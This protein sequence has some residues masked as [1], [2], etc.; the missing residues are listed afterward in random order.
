[1]SAKG[2]MSLNMRSA[3]WEKGS[4][5]GIRRATLSRLKDETEATLPVL[6]KADC[7]SVRKKRETRASA[8]VSDR[9]GDD[10]S[11]VDT[12]GV[13]FVCLPVGGV[14]GFESMK[15][16]CSRR[17]QVMRVIQKPR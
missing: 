7:M 1:M 5:T 8:R 3:P 16:A 4:K 15:T 6:K 11:D 14:L 12:T 10:D 9:K 13:P 2:I 17:T